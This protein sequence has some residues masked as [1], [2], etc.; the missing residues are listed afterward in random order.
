LG[1]R[2]TWCQLLLDAAL[3]G[4][5]FYR[6]VLDRTGKS[7]YLLK[8][9]FDFGQRVHISSWFVFS[10]LVFPIIKTQKNHPDRSRGGL[11][12]VVN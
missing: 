1:A 11:R 9:L 8:V 10:W 12:L 4:N 6:I 2:R 3:S 5:G 7:P